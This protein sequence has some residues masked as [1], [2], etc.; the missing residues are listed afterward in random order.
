[1][2]G[3]VTS[4][5][6]SKALAPGVMGWFQGDYNEWSTEYTALFE[7]VPSGRQYEED[8][9]ES[10][11]GLASVKPEG[12]NIEYD[13]T[14]QNFIARYRPVVQAKGFIVT[15]EMY[16]DDQYGVIARKR[17]RALARSMRITK[18]MIAANIINRGFNAAYKMG[19]DHDGQP[20][21][22]TAHPL[23]PYGGTFSNKL[24]VDADLT[25][26]ALEQAFID[27]GGYV[28]PRGLAISAQ[29]VS[30][31][32]PRQLQF[33]ASRILDSEYR[34]G[35]DLNDVNAIRQNGLLPQG[36]SVNHYFTDPDGWYVKTNVPDGLKHIDRRP[37][38]FADDSGFDNEN[39][40]FKSTERYVFGWSD[41]RG[42]HG[43][44]GAA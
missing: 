3:V 42:V 30:L 38:E 26:A 7:T 24:L 9:G 6:F 16:E 41:P 2:V 11:F 13:D 44:A 31:C 22:S 37:I 1:M 21:F 29:P 15:R 5:S 10:G 20:L 4:G 32:V 23:G 28:D 39:A 25:E 43:S 40:K 35:T 12:Q 18:E 14:E 33:E 36:F 19:A 17:A 34:P 8:V 27:I